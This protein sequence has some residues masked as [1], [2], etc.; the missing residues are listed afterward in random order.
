MRKQATDT[1][2][3]GLSTRDSFLAKCC[4]T[5]CHINGWRARHFCN[6][7]LGDDI[8]LLKDNVKRAKVGYFQRDLSV[9][10]CVNRWGCKMDQYARPG[11]RA[12][13]I[14]E[15]NQVCILVGVGA[16]DLFRLPQQETEW[17]NHDLATTPDDRLKRPVR[18]LVSICR[19]RSHIQDHDQRGTFDS[20][21]PLVSFP[22]A[23]GKGF[24]WNV[25][26]LRP[27]EFNEQLFTL[28]S[29]N[30]APDKSIELLAVWWLALG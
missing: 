2:I 26:N 6:G 10:R 11:A 7:Q 5:A 16:N 12:F 23:L 14:D 21:T 28:T 17:S 1:I 30:A 19:I 25:E 22:A 29:N 4:R 15:A 18:L 3:Y 20:F 27:W 13:A 9:P 24:R 8:V